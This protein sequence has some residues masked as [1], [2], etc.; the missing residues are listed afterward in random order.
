M[1][2]GKKDNE[3]SSSGDATPKI[4]DEEKADDKM[5]MITARMN[6]PVCNYGPD[7]KCS[8]DVNQEGTKKEEPKVTSVSQ[9]PNIKTVF[10]FCLKVDFHNKQSKFIQLVSDEEEED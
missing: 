2:S 5:Q 9:L 6:I 8:P 4:L 1:E 10:D 7:C 3:D